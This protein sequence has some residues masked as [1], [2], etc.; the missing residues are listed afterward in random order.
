[1]NANCQN[2]LITFKCTLRVNLTIYRVVKAKIMP[3][4]LIKQ[5]Y[6]ENLNWN[7]N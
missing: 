7:P 3:N 6:S 5:N 2:E 1:M 4:G